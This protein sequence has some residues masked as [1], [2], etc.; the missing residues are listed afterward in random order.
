MF[1]SKFTRQNRRWARSAL[2]ASIVK[3]GI[4]KIANLLFLKGLS[5]ELLNGGYRD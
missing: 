5:W 4:M 3:Q 1:L 2:I